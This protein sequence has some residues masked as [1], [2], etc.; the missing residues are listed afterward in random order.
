LFKVNNLY[1]NFSDSD[2]IYYHRELL[3]CSLDNRRVDLL[4][5]SACNNT[6]FKREPRFDKNLFPNNDNPRPYNFNKKR[7]FVLT[8]RVHP[9]ETPASF[10]FNGFLEFIL[11]KDDPR[12]KA[13]RR[14]FVFKLIPLLNP[15][16]VARGHY[17]TDQLGMNL[18]RV[19]LDPS[20]AL[21]PTIY[22][23]KSLIVF[24][25]VNNRINKD[26][27]CLNF[28]GI[29]DFK[30]DLPDE[31]EKDDIDDCDKLGILQ[32]NI[33]IIDDDFEN[34]NE[35]ENSI[36]NEINRIVSPGSLLLSASSK[37]QHNFFEDKLAHLSNESFHKKFENLNIDTCK[38]NSRADLQSAKSNKLLLSPIKKVETTKKYEN[39]NNNSSNLKQNHDSKKSFNPEPYIGN[40]NSDEEDGN[41]EFIESKVP[42]SPHLN[43]PRLLAIDPLCSGIGFYVDLH[44]HAAKRG[45]YF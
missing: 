43:D 21:H 17:R 33:D 37:R 39:E 41:N 14:N 29:F 4:T 40:E 36:V 30:Y 24:H 18:N 12:A 5:I 26:Q 8:S 42:N 13:L 32:N 28:D 2:D 34:G 3:C 44:G 35:I 15:D 45:F 19:Y 23:A 6:N 27:D 9:G 25:H 10:V 16:G 1:Q 22:A 7:V 20:F 11:N 38:N 31:K